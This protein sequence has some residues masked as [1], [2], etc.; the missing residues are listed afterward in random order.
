MTSQN[1]SQTNQSQLDWPDTPSAILIMGKRQGTKK[2]NKQLLGRVA[3]AA[4]L[5]YSAPHPKPYLLFV[6]SD[7]SHNIPDVA[8]VK[9]RLMR[10]FG[11]PG[12]YIIGRCRSNCTL[13]EVRVARILNRRYQFAH[14]FALT[15]LYHA[16]RVQRYLDEVLPNA[17]VIPVHPTIFNELTFPVEL[18]SL[19]AELELI[20]QESQL[21]NLDFVRETIVEWT[22]SA[23]HTVDRRGR[24]ERCLANRWRT[25]K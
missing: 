4:A 2:H 15:H 3:M 17:S 5:W 16:L 19:F 23:W 25:N 6:A 14:I 9:G 21:S 18:E 20:I 10:Q 8:V 12:D 7:V 24:V 11:I 13:L 1:K 22:L